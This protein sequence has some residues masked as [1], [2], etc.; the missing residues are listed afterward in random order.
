MDWSVLRL[1]LDYLL[2]IADKLAIGA[3]AAAVTMGIEHF[4][5][6]TLSTALYS[7]Q[8]SIVENP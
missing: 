2:E 7:E 5:K 8:Y 1:I 4:K 6:T 3:G